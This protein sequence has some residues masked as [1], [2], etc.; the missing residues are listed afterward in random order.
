VAEKLGVGTSLDNIFGTRGGPGVALHSKETQIG[1]SASGAA[2]L[3][4]LDNASLATIAKGGG[5]NAG[6]AANDLGQRQLTAMQNQAADVKANATHV[7][8]MVALYGPNSAQAKQ[9][10]AQLLTVT[11]AFSGKAAKD[12]TVGNLTARMNAVSAAIMGDQVKLG[13]LHEDLANTVAKEGTLKQNQTALQDNKNV[14]HADLVAG[15]PAGVIA[16]VRDKIVTE[17]GHIVDIKGL[18]AKITKTEDVLA[19]DKSLKSQL[20]A[21]ATQAAALQTKLEALNKSIVTPR[22]S[23]MSGG[24]T[25]RVVS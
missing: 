22:Q 6:T 10:M 1:S 9:A 16:S 23:V 5:P 21:Q 8:Q 24:I 15:A 17:T 12:T 14:L 2:I 3:V 7:A 19:V 18:Q 13:A 11:N 4:H 25:M 20:T